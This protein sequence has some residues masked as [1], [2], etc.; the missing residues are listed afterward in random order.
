[1]M[2]LSVLT[3]V[4]AAAPAA[5]GDASAAP[6]A[7]TESPTPD[8]VQTETDAEYRGCTMVIVGKNASADGSVVL[9]RTEDYSGNWAKHF[10]HVPAETHPEGA[11]FEAANGLEWPLPNETYAY[12]A[13]QDWTTEWGR[14]HEFAIN[15]EGVG[16]TATTTTSINED[17]EE[18]DPLVEGGLAEASVTTLV[19]QR[20]DTPREGVELV[21]EIVE[22]E[23]ASEP[24]AM[25]V[26]NGTEAWLIETASG[27]HWAAHRIPDDEYFVGA[28]AMRLGEV[29]LDSPD[30]MGS[31]GLIDFAAEHD[32]YDPE[33]E[34][35]HFAKAYGTAD[36]YAAYNYQRVWGGLE[37][38]G[39][40]NAPW[41]GDEVPG[42]DAR[43]YPVTVEPDE[44]I[45]VKDVMDFTRYRYQDT[46]YDARETD[47]PLPRTVGTTSTIE[48][49]ILQLREDG[50]TPI[51]DVAWAAMGTP[52]AS[53]YVPYYPALEEFPEP[54]RQGNDTY[55][56]DSAFWQFRSLSNLRFL[57]YDYFG[58]K[59]IEEIET[60]EEAELEQ[61]AEKERKAA[62]LWEENETKARE[63]LA[64]YSEEQA[65]EAL[66]LAD[67]L[68]TEIHTTVAQIEGWKLANPSVDA[69]PEEWDLPAPDADADAD[70]PE[71]DD[72][73]ADTD[74]PGTDDGDDTSDADDGSTDDADDG[75]T[76][77]AD[78]GSTDDADGETDAD[79][80]TPG[81]GVA[82]AAV[83]IA[84]L[85]AVGAATRRR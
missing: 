48:S 51:S 19:A 27:H 21:G 36:D 14:F 76:D 5:D 30:Y 54:Y 71:P 47:E 72:D 70:E 55:D 53:P 23:G 11:T 38:F 7:E 80:S 8:G 43:P 65:W 16:V 58:P 31:D 1:M 18:V 9:A 3:P 33:T 34:D 32:L 42:P 10:R 37:Y 2:V 29:D 39:T 79:D 67:D 74:D 45:S 64:N 15:S 35:F 44:E 4:A 6:A 73:N 60:F 61:Q 84:A 52:L 25:A 13:A 20:A 77:D 81:F 22:Q 63:Y 78:D 56:E 49:H 40:E 66:D 69:Q 50:P 17:V 85:I 82:A 57:S 62:E 28:N 59:V 68:E 26:A 12:N 75:S 46:E 83:A 41:D 24:F